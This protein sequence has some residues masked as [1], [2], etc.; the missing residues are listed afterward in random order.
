MRFPVPRQIL[1]TP[2]AIDN[3]RLQLG[4]CMSVSRWHETWWRARF[5]VVARSSYMYIN[6][7]MRFKSLSGTYVTRFACHIFHFICHFFRFAIERVV[8]HPAAGD[9]CADFHALQQHLHLQS[10]LENCAKFH[11]AY[12]ELQFDNLSVGVLVGKGN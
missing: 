4:A 2:S 1:H 8:A 12:K 5:F 9:D 3:T 7:A 10:H 6:A 11:A